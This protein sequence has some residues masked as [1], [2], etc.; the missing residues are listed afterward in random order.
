MMKALEDMKEKEALEKNESIKEELISGT[1]NELFSSKN[2]REDRQN[3]AALLT[4][5]ALCLHS[6]TEGVAMGSSLYRK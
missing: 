6:L 4:T 1:E 5:I 2:L 3:S